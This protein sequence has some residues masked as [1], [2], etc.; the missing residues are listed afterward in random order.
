M[1]NEILKQI[2]DHCELASASLSFLDA[3]AL[4]EDIFNIKIEINQTD[5]FDRELLIR[6][7][8][9]ALIFVHTDYE[10]MKKVYARK[11]LLK[12]VFELHNLIFKLTNPGK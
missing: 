9:D 10:S 11:E 2:A 4:Q 3:G 12:H 1:P 7:L 6:L 8:E 5:C